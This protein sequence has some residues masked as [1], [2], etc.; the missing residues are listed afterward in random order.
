VFCVGGWSLH[1]SSASALQI[2]VQAVGLNFHLYFVGGEV[3]YLIKHLLNYLA[4]NANYFPP[5]GTFSTK[6][7]SH[8]VFGIAFL[9]QLVYC[10][11]LEAHCSL[12]IQLFVFILEDES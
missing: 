5:W 2:C 7:A 1:S 11:K 6:S 4:F 8:H 10:C 9:T 12:L 3:N